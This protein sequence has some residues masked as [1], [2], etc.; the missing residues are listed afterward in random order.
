MKMPDDVKKGLAA[1]ITDLHFGFLAI[2]GETS[3]GRGLFSL[4][5]YPIVGANASMQSAKN[6]SDMVG[7]LGT[8][9]GVHDNPEVVYERILKC[10]EEVFG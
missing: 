1:T 8:A 4:T 9:D 5:N 10:V 6:Q 2:G 7:E 3:I